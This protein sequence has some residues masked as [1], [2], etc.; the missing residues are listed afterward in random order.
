MRITVCELPHEP[1]L[2]AHAWPALCKHAIQE[3]SELVLLPEFAFAE[4]VWLAEHFDSAVWAAAQAACD[5]WLSRLPE[6]GVAHV[7]GTRPVIKAGKPYNEGFLWSAGL[8]LQALRSK[9]HLP[10]EPG[11]WEARWFTRG[12]RNFPAF[13]AGE[14]SFGL[15][16]C[17][18]LWALENCAVYA[19]SGVAAIL[20]P[21]ATAFA[22]TEK[23]LSL[24]TV[25]AVRTGAF[26]LSSNRVQADGSCGGVGWMIGP[27]G[28]LLAKTSAQTPFCTLDLS[29]GQAA[30]ARK[31]YP[32][33]VFQGAQGAG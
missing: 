14:L 10:E 31:T 24:G 30:A 27:D 9:V 25:V 7:V 15:S 16:I 3:A 18:E 6:L 1:E 12:D 32:R 8:G 26:S 4:P 29:F 13:R 2:L 19:Q 5:Q 21:R 33:Y 22:T 28:E 17:T 11:G 23:W 20:S